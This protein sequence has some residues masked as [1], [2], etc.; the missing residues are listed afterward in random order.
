MSLVHP[1]VLAGFFDFT[2]QFEGEV[3]CMYR[4]NKNLIT[5]GVGDLIDPVQYALGLPWRH[6]SSHL[7]ATRQEIVDEWQRIKIAHNLDS[8]GWRA[9]D[10]IAT[11]YLAPEDIR[12][13]VN[14]KL[15][16][17]IKDVDAMYPTWGTWPADAQM[18]LLSM[19]W[20]MGDGFH[21]PV[22]THDAI[23]QDWG[24]AAVACHI[25]DSHN[26]GLVPRNAANRAL[27]E[28]AAAVY[29]AGADISV[30]HYPTRLS[31]IKTVHGETQSV[32]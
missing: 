28:N 14:S 13:L 29:Q 24:A 27:F 18:G 21:F 31:G 2:V 15:S 3:A 26:S 9:A 32:S 30:L 16:S 17:I 5:C 25:E 8:L 23:G 7:F 6:K 22:W 1:S 11:L 19:C 12:A 10:A 4:D 20:A